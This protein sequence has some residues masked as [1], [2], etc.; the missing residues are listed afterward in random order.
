MPPG[1]DDPRKVFILTTAGNYFSLDTPASPSTRTP[2][3][4]FLDDGNEFLLTVSRH[5]DKLQFSNKLESMDGGE[6]VLVFF[7][8][9]PCVIS[10]ENLHRSVLVSSMLES[11]ISTLYQAL[12]Q[13]YGP[14]LLQDDKWSESFDSKL[15]SLLTDLEVG[16]GSVLRHSH[17]EDSGKHRPTET[18]V[19]GIITPLDE[20]QYWTDVSRSGRHSK[21]RDRAAHF[22]ELFRTIEKDYSNLD[23]F[24]LVEVPDLIESTR[25]TVD[26]VWKQ[27]EH[28]PYPETR[29][30]R[31]MDVIGGALARLVQRKLSSLH[32][33]EDQYFTVREGLKGGVAV[34]EQWVAACEHLTGQVWKRYSPHPWSSEKHRPQGLQSLAQRLEEVLQ[35][36]TVCEKLQRLVSGGTQQVSGT[37]VYQPFTGLNPIHYN[38]YTEPLWRAAVSQF[39]RLITPA[40]QEA[41][42][43]L[44]TL[45]RDAQDSPQQLLQVFQKHRDLIRRATISRELQPERETLLTRLLDYNKGLRADFESR[46]HGAP[47]EKM[48]PLVGRNLPEVV[49]NIVWVR[50]LLL[51]VEDSLKM[52]E[53][54]LSDLSGFQSLVRFS[55]EL[56]DQLRSYEQ[57]QFEDWTRDLL[58]GLSD[59]KSGISLQASSRVMELDHADGTLKIQY[60]DRLVSLLREVRQ[61]SALGFSIPAKIQQAANTAEKF[62]RQAI[63][64]K[65]VAHFYNTIDQQMIPSQRPMMLSCALAFEQVIKQQNPRSQSHNEGGKLQITWENPKDLEQYISKLQSAAERLSTENRKLRK[66]HTDFTDKVVLLMGVDLLRQQQ[67]W[68]DGLQD[69]RT[70]FASLESQGFRSG[71]MKA[72]RQHWNHQLYKALEHQYQVG[73]EALNKNLPEINIDLVF[74]QGRLQFRPAFEEVRAK[75]YREMKRFICIPNQFKGVSEAGEEP[76]FN[77]MIERNASGFLTIFSK[78]EHLFSRLTHVLEKFK[79][80][81]VLGQVDVDALVEKHLYSVQDWE[82]NF[83][84]LKAKGK[85]VERLPSTEKV[86]CITVNCEPVKVA[87]DD[88]IQ[89][90]FDALLSFLRRSIQGHIQVIDSFLS[91]AMEIL[92][93][94]P[95]SIDEIG[96]ANAKHGHLQTQKPEIL[97][98][99]QQAEEKNKLLRSVAGGGLDSISAL[100]AKWDKFELMMESH[101]LM[102]KEQVEVMKGNVESQVQVYLQ[103]LQKFRARWDQL[104][105]SYDIIESG[106]PETLQTCAQNIRD[107]RAEF[108]E[109]EKT[110]IKLMEDCEHFSLIS[111]DVSLAID[112][113]RN[114]EECSVMWELYEEF[115]KGL[116]EN[117]EQDWI[118]FR[119]KTHMF[120]EFLFGWQDRLRKLEEH[121][122]MSVKLQKEVDRF[123]AVVPVLKYVRG[124]HLSQEHWLDLFRLISLPR[125][126]TLERLRF[127]DLLAV[128]DNIVEKS[129]ELKDL[130]SR[131]QAEVTIREALREL[132]LWAAGACFSLTDYTDSQGGSLRVIRDWRDVVNQ[133]GDNRCLLQSLKDSPYYVRFQDKVSLWETRL[134]D[135][136]EYLQNLNT[137]QRKWVYLEPI[138]GRGALPREQ[139]RFQRV[140]QD[141]RAIMSDVQRDSRVASLTTRAGI[142]NSLVTILDQLQRCQKSLNEFLEEKRSA[143][144]RFYFIGDDDLLEI[145]GQATNPTV[146]HTHLK[147]LFA[148]ISS[149]EFDENFQSI[150]AM[151]SLEGETV[152]LQSNI[153]ISNDVEVWLSALSEEMKNTLKYLLCECVKAG[154]RGNV[155]PTRFP[156]QILC[157]A[158][159]IQFTADVENAIRHQSL[160]QL[161]QELMAKLENYTSVNTS[162]DDTTETKVVRL[163]LKAL[164]LDVIHNISVVQCLKEAQV[165]SVDDWAWRKQLR[166]YLNSDQCCSIQMVDAEFNY[167]YEYQ[168]NTSKLV[169]TPLTDKCYLTLTQAMKMGL[170][171]NPYGPAGTGKTESVKALGGLFGRQVLVFNCDEG[172]DVKSMGRIFVGLVKCGA[173]G[174]FDEFNRLEEAVL[175]AVSMQIQDIQN[176]LKNHR[177]TCQL[178]NKEVELDPNSGIFITMNPAGKGYGGRQKLPDNLKQLF[179]PVAMTSPD[180]ELIAEVILYSEGFKEGK[181]LGRKLVAIFNLAREL[182]MPQQHYDWG[183]RALK[184]VLSGCGSLLQ[185]QKQNNNPI[186]ESGLVVQALRLNTMSKLT[187]ADSS[188]FDALVSDVFPGVDFKDVEYETLRSALVAVYEEARLEIIP[189]QIKKALELY[190][191]LRQRMGVVI[192]GPSGAGKS[193]LWRMLRAALGKM[194]RV[195][196][197]Y[198]MN[199]KAMPRQ[200]LLGHIDMDTREWS[201]GVLTS[202]ARQVV[203]EPQEVNSWIIC[204]GDIDPEWIESL[205]SVLDDNRLLTMPSGERIQ[206]GPNVNFLFETHDLSC[207][208]PATISR[209]GMI[210]LSDEDTDVGSLVKSWLK[211]EN[212]ENRMNLE[213]WLNDYFQKAL[214]WVLK[215]SDFVVDTS[216]VGTVLNGLSHLRGVTERGQFVVGLIRGL[217]GNLAFKCRQEFAK[218]VLSWARETPPDPRKPLD[219]YYDPTSGRLCV[220]E[221]QRGDGVCVED[222]NNPQNLPVIHT[223]D[224]QRGLDLFT[225]WLS[226]NHRQ[227]FLLVGPE[228]CGKGMLLRC[229]FSQLRSTQV[230]VVHCSAQT[231]SRHVLQKLSHTCLI[232]SSNTGRVYRPKDCER[233][234][235]YLKDI[236]LPKPDK[237]GTSNLI[238]FLQQV[239]TYQ[240]FYDEHLEWVGLENIQIV[241]SMSAGGAVG[242]HPLTS[243]FTSIVRICTIDYPDREQLQTIYSAYLRP[244]LQST[245]GN[246]PT[247]SSAGKIHQ[248]ASSLVQIYEQVKAKFSVDDHSHYLF[249]PC[250]LTQWVLNLLRYDLSTGKSAVD[251]VLEVVAYEARRLFRDRLVTSKDQNVFDNILSSVIR[252]DW[253]SDALDNMT[254]TYFVTWATSHEGRAPGQSLPPHGKPLGCLNANDLSEIIHKG[255]V[256]YGR[257]NRELDILLFPEVLDYMSR[258][259][260]VLS[261]PGGSLLLA[262]RSGVGRRTATSVVSHMH[263]ATLFTPKISRSYSLKHFKSDLKTVMQLAAVDGQQVVLLL[264]DHQFVHPSFLEMVNSLLSSGEVPGL[265]ST[266]ELEPLLSSLKDQASQDSFTAPILNYFS[267]RVQQNLHVVLIMDCTNEHFTIN[268][269]S[270]PA[271]YRK[272]SVQWME[273]WSD[274]SM[275]KIPEMLLSRIGEDEKNGERKK[276]KT[277][278]ADLYR[279]FLM[280]HE[281]CREFGATPSQ[282]LSFLQV[283]QS[284][285]SSKRKELTKKQQHLQAGVAKLNEAKALV[286]EL[287]RR[288]AEQSSLL[289]T[290]QAEAD[291][292]L[293]EITLSMQNASDQKTE[294]EK[295]KERMAKEVT[296]I[297]ERKKNIDEELREVQPLVDEAK[298]AVGNIKSE[299]LSEI[300]SLRMPPDVIRDILEGVLRLMGIFDT[301]WVSMKSFLAKRGVREDIVT[302]DARNITHEIRQSVEELLHRNRA[303]FD[304]KNAKRASAAAAPLAAWVKAN[305]QYSHVLERIQPLESEHAGLM[306]NLRKT[307]NRKNKLEKE[308]NSVG[309]KVLEL[310]EKFQCRTTEAAQLESEVNR[311]QETISAAEKL[312]QQLDGEHTR[313]TAQVDEI[314]EQLDTL[315]KR[316]QLSAAFITYLPA[317]PEDQRRINLDNWINT[318]G[319]EKFDLR[320]FLCSESE[321]LIWKSEGLPSDDLS[322]ENAL[323]ILQLNE[324]RSQSVSCPFLID[325]SSRATEWLRTHLKE[326][327]LEIINQQDANFMTVLEL[328]VRFGKTLIIQE[329]DG[330]EPVLYPLLRRDL[331]AQGPRYVVQIGDKVIDY[332]EDFRLFLATRNPSPFIPPDAASVITKVN[333]TTT[334][335]GLRGQLLALTIQQEKPE[336]ES[337]KTKVLQQEEEKKIQL[338]QLEESLLETLATAQ[339][340][341]LE[342]KELIESLNQ[343]KASSALIHQSLT[344]SHRLQTSLDQ[345]RDAYLPLTE[346]ASK[347]Y[348]VIVDLSKINNMYRFSL[349]SFLRLFHRALQNKQ[350]SES[351]DARIS[352]LEISLKNMVYEYICRSLFKADQLMF[353]LHFVK[354]MNPELFQENEWDVFTGLVVGDVVRKTDSQKSLREQFPSWIDQERLT[355]VALLKTTFPV[356]YQTLC[357]NDTD[358]WLPFSRSSCCEQ[359]VPPSVAK[360]ISLFQQVLVVQALRPDRLQSAM[361]SFASHTLG[362]KE[363]SPPP[364]NL[365]RLYEETLE[366]EPI[367]LIIS[368]GA[369]PSQEL[370][371]LAGQIVGRE[372]YHEVAMGQGQ[373]DVALQMLRECARSGEW[374][375]LK[376]LHLVTAWLPLLEKELNSIKPKAGFRIWLTAEVH[377]KFTPILLQSSLKVTY[378]APPGLK[379]NLKRTYES[380]SPEQISKGGQLA[381]AQSLFC[382]AWFHAVCQERRNYIPQGWTKFYEFS[383]SDLRAGFEIIDRLFEGG[384]VCQWEY[385]HGLLENAIYGGRID[386]TC[387]LRVL[388]SYLQQFFN[389]QLLTQTHSRMKKTHTFPA[390]IHLPNSCSIAD[391]RVLVDGLPEDDKP[392]FFGLP[393]N[394]ERS[395][396]RIIS[397]QVISQLRIL[398]RP[399][400]AGSKFDRELWSNALSP[401]LNLWK[402]LNQGSSM[403]HQKVAAPSEGVGSPVLSFI[404]LEQ[405]NAVRLVQNIHQSLASLSKVIRGT[406]LL[407]AD[408]HKLATALLNQECPLSWQNKWEGPEEPMQYLRSVVS[409]ALAI[410]SWVERAERG[411]LLSEMLDLSE[412]FHPDTFLNALRQETARLMSCSMDSLKFVTSWR[413]QITEAKLQVK[414]GGLQLE[415]CSFDGHRLA[416]SQHDS[417]SVSAVPP[418]FMAW[419]PR[420]ALGSYSPDECISLPVYSSSERPRVVTSVQ[421]PCAGAHDTWI[422][423]GAAL[424][425]KLQ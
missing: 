380:W 369:D 277:L 187:F 366:T 264:E 252:G 403:I 353:A 201:D 393:A 6:G 22:S 359:E 188:R 62:Y 381:R 41:A 379:K 348:F 273:G 24:S 402:R 404:Q 312:L 334:R 143:F 235:L 339:G 394:I 147:K 283:Y 56:Q 77:R 422:Q 33:W 324:L 242:R 195:V 183:L 19:L 268:C 246:D 364:L 270:N 176:S 347:M 160:H 38:P 27:N 316:A 91:G 61:L 153:S 351:T 313:W 287:K 155:D 150:T 229:A 75:Y 288:A 329:M 377:V 274:S 335:A 206:F 2:L 126:T 16:L 225:P 200:Q 152:L 51:K 344:E 413:G 280:I 110:R 65:Q 389:T 184:T 142:R 424:F 376:N 46:C 419:I 352:T 258:I 66:W 297:E 131:A 76:I 72:W 170:G 299:S 396:Q 420:T 295:I 388:R 189:S 122:S 74:K 13:V 275:R 290:K 395:A 216:L 146:I 310:K 167:T 182:L 255:I 81:V 173:W 226:S 361:A 118:S 85:E 105:P 37:R 243:R 350:E 205:N 271:V 398:S 234:V 250:L 319:L 47:G 161:E 425:L 4:N 399:V 157:L 111:P 407:T 311:A 281:S 73:L 177:T 145:L 371:E 196:K 171:G 384:K 423:S 266:E 88:L 306:E 390:Q 163:K 227:P 259:N 302:F 32:L 172:I 236:N 52:S 221:L 67:R 70:G 383:L 374:L 9:R 212:E 262:G 102:I 305:V 84:A 360:K 214:D 370:L 58:S 303:S 89:G 232:I 261:S 330:V 169:H 308:L 156:S 343:T 5:E 356:L 220:Y 414:V 8:P 207:A 278:H 109:L 55:S 326:H 29:M 245:L 357:L 140:D 387:D 397:S 112:T 405:F 14:V 304:P 43:K 130:N 107:R 209:M 247:W 174:C 166:F 382:L 23:S 54:L 292:A 260:R 223:T 17:A 71:D 248:L 272:C 365:K 198:T 230:A 315:P 421:L 149:V 231:S 68:K 199:P 349:A 121:N 141:L 53:V 340:N 193:T 100:R 291:A 355:A 279:S 96:E 42:G 416:E 127:R 86:D 64:L 135:L 116:S 293:Q 336:L 148:G 133:V 159:Q 92:S 418:C 332:N 322:M 154:Q 113:L 358:L 95:E 124:E 408:V 400:A 254:D 101:Q 12:R 298:Q 317:A 217:G 25:E 375:C 59:P 79:D 368:A 391:Y 11:P 342:N 82:R 45:I 90:L 213:N 57:E 345:E 314:S 218:E 69:L 125:G 28:G 180:N 392:S 40:E 139:A 7:K 415:G 282:Y 108:D 409:R 412:L 363:L 378:E 267:H 362:M 296:K 178:L 341:I 194:G 244:V 385:A 240:G 228:G 134:A 286:D 144:P 114:L 50:Q 372:N 367:L 106:D 190:E 175:S 301:S 48:G 31:L 99:F 215:Q 307:E 241:A 179:R 138:F 285:Y 263:G 78:A 233:L 20:F 410:Q 103:D 309:E 60:S 186:K 300:R 331:I 87:V 185:S 191:Q 320:H 35:V 333:F 224:M 3:D 162:T 117:A 251:S 44:K 249:T 411:A 1:R 151:K 132:E 93:S 256:L 120:E 128:A 238:A 39:D 204:D 10:E 210:F 318:S 136:D 30:I 26:D 21:E 104:K 386:N 165:L 202:S 18:D 98:Q 83:K 80:W 401:V 208:S 346:T 15:Q 338:A 63:V 36:R 373:A 123:K 284:I 257:E 97:P 49:N 269:E 203:R 158:E 321:Q 406:S 265:Y 354:G 239:L 276:K 164:I 219:T 168:G 34:C 325:P 129:L 211:R 119:S 192:V 197:Q 417:P 253:S 222:L 328:A 289:K 327:R 115:Q 323:V 181:M 237:W 94:R 294:M 137:I 337:Q